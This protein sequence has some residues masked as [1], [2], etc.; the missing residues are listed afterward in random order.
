MSL[1]LC[2]LAG[3]DVTAKRLPAFNFSGRSKLKRLG[4]AAP[5]FH[6]WHMLLFLCCWFGYI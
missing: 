5:G 6:F 1:A 2:G 3:Q 4:S